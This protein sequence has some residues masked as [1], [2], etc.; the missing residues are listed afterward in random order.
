MEIF[1]IILLSIVLSYLITMATYALLA[2]FVVIHNYM[3]YWKLSWENP[4]L[5][6]YNLILM[7]ISIISSDWLISHITNK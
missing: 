6:M 2:E 3:Q 7:G 1:I 4:T 5:F